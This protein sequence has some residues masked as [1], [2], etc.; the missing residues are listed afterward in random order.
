MPEAC[1]ATTGPRQHGFARGFQTG[2]VVRGDERDAVQSTRDKAFK[3]GAPVH[4]G[5]RHLYRDAEYATAAKFV[6]ANRGQHRAIVGDAVFA[7]FF[8]PRVKE[9]VAEVSER[10]PAPGFKI[11]IEQLGGAADL[12]R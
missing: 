4:L 5:L 9:D 11:S 6:H 10:T 1:F 8:V 2:V 7:G 3:E 12:G